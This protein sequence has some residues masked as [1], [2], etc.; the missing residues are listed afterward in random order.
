MSGHDMAFGHVRNVAAMSFPKTDQ[1]S[2]L[3]W[4]QSHGKARA[5]TVAPGGPMH[6][7]EDGCWL[8]LADVPKSVFQHALLHGDLGLRIDML[9]GTAPTNAKVGA[10]RIHPL[11]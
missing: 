7:R 2:A 5:V 4:H 10:A 11:R 8:E 6:G 3:T 1:Y 9:H